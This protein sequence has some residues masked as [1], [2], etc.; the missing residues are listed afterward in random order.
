MVCHDQMSSANEQNEQNRVSAAQAGNDPAGQNFQTKRENSV[1]RLARS[2]RS[3]SKMPQ[4]VINEFTYT[5]GAIHMIKKERK[6]FLK[7]GSRT[8]IQKKGFSQIT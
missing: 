6:I 3:R 4:I 8:L 7:T 5:Y 2:C 1:S